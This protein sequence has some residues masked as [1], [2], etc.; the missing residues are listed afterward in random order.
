MDDIKIGHYSEG[1]T[2]VTVVLTP[3]GAVGGCSVRGSAPAT[4]ETALL[5]SHKMIQKIHAVCL[6][7]GSAFG[8]DA[9]GGVMRWL[10]ERGYGFDA[11]HKVP[12]VCGASIFDLTRTGGA[13]PS[14]DMGY[15]ACEN[16]M[17]KFPS[18]GGVSEGRGGDRTRGLDCIRP[19]KR[20]ISSNGTCHTATLGADCVTTPTSKSN[21]GQIGAGT[22]ATIG[23]IC[24]AEFVAAGGIGFASR[25]IGDLEITA[26]VVVNAVGDIV[27]DGKIIAGA[28][29]GG[30]FLDC[31]KMLMGALASSNDKQKGQNTTLGV[32]MTNADMTKVEVNKLA[33]ITHNAYAMCISPVHTEFDGDIIFGLATGKIKGI[34][35]N[36]VA[37]NAIDVMKEAIW[38]VAHGK[39]K[40]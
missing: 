33:D 13:K 32:I 8:L 31:N 2:G 14:A 25:K 7:G 11:G 26:L 10:S 22:G 15:K 20:T 12:I 40:G 3:K 37:A 36:V 21:N 24:G 5:D 27:K 4:R 16:A 17:Q 38:S 6:S 39:S 29:K 18:C 30:K 23:K 35:F 19:S 28:N 9:C 1:G 34:D